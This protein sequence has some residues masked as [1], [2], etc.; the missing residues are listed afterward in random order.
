MRLNPFFRQPDL[1]KVLVGG[2]SEHFEI[3]GVT[4][5]QALDVLLGDPLPKIL[6]LDILVLFFLRIQGFVEVAE[7]LVG[8]GK[9]TD[10][11]DI[12][13]SYTLALFSESMVTSA[14]P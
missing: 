9:N 13:L 1:L 4:L 3:L 14:I 11:K 12:I 7:I 5:G 10:K 8:S 6:V 2:V